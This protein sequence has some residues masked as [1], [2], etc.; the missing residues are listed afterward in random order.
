MDSTQPFA[1]LSAADIRHF[2]DLLHSSFH[3]ALMTATHFDNE[4]NT[5]LASKYG[6]RAGG[7][8]HA[9]ELLDMVCNTPL[10]VMEEAAA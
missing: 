1:A 4:G 9:I 3:S 7:L 10:P 6:G 8:E 2:R 5:L